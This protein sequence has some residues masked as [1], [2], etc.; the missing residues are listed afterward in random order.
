MTTR[1]EEAAEALDN[2][3][4]YEIG[5]YVR[6]LYA[7]HQALLK[8]AKEMTGENCIG[9]V[10][11]PTA[12][13][14]YMK[15]NDTSRQCARDLIGA[16]RAAEAFDGGGWM[17]CPMCMCVELPELGKTYADGYRAGIEAAAKIADD[18]RNQFQPLS[19]WSRGCYSAAKEIGER[20][21]AL[22]EKTEKV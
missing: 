22:A 21:R 13:A 1:F 4:F 14:I 6:I 9:H 15:D 20:A 12:G 11:Y 19:D 7:S 5:T 18:V 3:G 17:K 10:R 8:A 2:E 16:I